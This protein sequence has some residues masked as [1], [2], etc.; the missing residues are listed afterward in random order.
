MDR[1]R[2][3]GSA[4]RTLLQLF[5]L[6]LEGSPAR[7]QLEENGFGSLA[8]IPELAPGGV[9]REALARDRELLHLEQPFLVDYRRLGSS[10][11]DHDSEIP[12]PCRASLLEELEP[13]ARIV[14]DH[15][16]CAP[17]ERRRDGTLRARLGS[18]RREHEL[19]TLLGERPRG[20]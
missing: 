5:D 15:G 9:V 4:L 6:G 11:A 1:G 17:T 20:G 2:G 12:Q 10:A 3:R 19:L 13:S 14:D 8:R 18:D 16:R 7:L